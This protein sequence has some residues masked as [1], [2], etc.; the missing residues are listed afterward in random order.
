MTLRAVL[1]ALGP[2]L[3]DAHATVVVDR[4]PV[5]MAE[6]TQL[7]Q[8]FQNLISNAVKFTAPGTVPRI[9]VT[10]ERNGAQCRFTVTDNGIGIDPEHRERIFGM[11][12]R[13]HTRE[14]YPGTG[15]GLALV[16]KIVEQHG[17]QVG[18]TDPPAPGVGTRFWFTLP[19]GPDTPP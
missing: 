12:K 5:V 14:D 19:A 10:A 1:G 17:G 13:L 11:F 2:T 3:D 18:V 8:V 7:A 6:P 16:K 4:L 9:T 15:I